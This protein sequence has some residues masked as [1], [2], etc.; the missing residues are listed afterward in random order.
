MIDLRP[1]LAETPGGEYALHLVAGLGRLE[2]AHSLQVLAPGGSQDA[3]PAGDVLLLPAGGLPRPGYRVVA[4]VSDL[5]HPLSPRRFGILAAARRGLGVA[6]RAHRSDRLF[7]PSRLVAEGLVR[8]L[9]ARPEAVAV[10][11]PGLEPWFT[12]TSAATVDDLRAELE[13]PDRYILAWGDPRRA[14]EAFAAAEK[15]R[16]AGL[17]LLE[18]LSSRRERWP[19]LLSGAVGTLL[20]D[21]AC[22]CPIFALM[23]MACG[24]PPVVTGDGAYPELVRDG[25]L[26]AA[27]AAELRDAVAALFRSRALRSMLS[28]Q[29]RRLASSLTAEA[30]ALQLLPLLDL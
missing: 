4:A 9:R 28:T 10:V 18:E 5:S 3:P 27:D 24:S 1:A 25:G 11:T 14:R 7:A 17:V 13:L 22:G 16:D 26:V 30:S 12:R 20:L 8:Y 2:L 29:A 23:A 15:P 21:R 19:A 6:F